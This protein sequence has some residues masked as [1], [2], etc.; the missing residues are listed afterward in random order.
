[1]VKAIYIY[2][3]PPLQAG[4]DTRSTFVCNTDGLNLEF[5]FS[6]AGCLTNTKE[7]SLSYYLSIPEGEEL[8]SCLS[9]I[10]LQTISSKIWTKV[11]D[12]VT[13]GDNRLA[14]HA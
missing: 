10:H 13:D 4:C 3:T 9:Q 5:S 14:K 1:M 6:Q 12:F 11:T 2:P 8:D 7:P